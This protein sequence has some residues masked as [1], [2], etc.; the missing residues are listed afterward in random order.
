MVSR[1]GIL[2][3]DRVLAKTKWSLV[4]TEYFSIMIE[5][6]KLG[7]FCR[8]I[9]FYVVTECSQMERFCVATEQFYVVT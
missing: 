9:I 7:V 6:A 2:C 1:H 8:D 4:A 5:L 3:R